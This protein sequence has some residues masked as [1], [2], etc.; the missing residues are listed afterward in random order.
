[1]GFRARPVAGAGT[2]PLFLSAEAR[3]VARRGQGRLRELADRGAQGQRP[4]DGD[5]KHGVPLGAVAGKRNP[6]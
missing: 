1:M 3:R 6:E 4:G 5:P 2:P